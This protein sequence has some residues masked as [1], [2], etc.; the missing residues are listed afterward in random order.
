M[1]RELF[2]L[3]LI[4]ILLFFV[5]RAGLY[6]LYADRMADMAFAES[7]LSFLYGLRLDTMAASIILVVPALVMAFAPARFAPAAGKFLHVYTL[8]FL[9]IALF[10]ENATFPFVAQYDVRPNYLFV[11]YLE[12][13][14]EV[15]SMIVK[16]YPFELVVA[17]LMLALAVWFYRRFRFFHFEQGMQSVWWKRAILFPLVGA[18]LFLGIRSSLG[19]RP[20]NISD[21]LYSTNRMANEIAKNSLYSI[22]YAYKS[23][24]SE[25]SI[26][27]RYGRI[28][29]D[30]A[31][32][33]VSERLD[34]PLGKGFPFSRTVQSRFPADKPKNLVIFIQ[35]SMGAQ[36]VGFSGGDAEITPNMDKLSR[37]AL[38]FT[39]L[40]SNGTR[41]I[42]G[43][44]AMTSGWLPLAGEEVVKRNKSQSGFFTVASL[45]KP[46][47]Y[48]SSFIYGG[49]GRFDNMRSW[50]MGN[51]FDEVIEQKDFDSPSFVSSWGVCDEDLVVR[52]N[53]KFREHTRKGEKFVSVMFSQSNHSPF[54]LPDGKIEFIPGQPRQSA[55]NAIKYADFAI[56]R[57]FE[58]AK[59]EAYYKDT[60]FVV[61]ADHNVR[62]Y[63]DDTVP[64]NMFHIP[65][66]IVSEGVEPQK[67]DRIATQPDVLATA[68]DL[69]GV[70]L[71]Y[72]ILGH[73][74]FDESNPEVAFMMFNDAFAL[75][76]RDRVAILEPDK[77][78]QT[79][80]YDNKRLNPVPHDQKLERDALAL[81]T[82]LDDLYAKKL[83]RP[84]I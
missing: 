46:L 15:S 12:Y 28:D 21:A 37:D 70:D 9:L 23:Y 77:A 34:L 7:L 16:E 10:V 69:V 39:N 67:F 49:E 64:V 51:G 52:A 27:K 3:Y 24:R 20:A 81:I 72:P 63:G 22:G 38:V 47:G 53:E 56:G 14:Q 71:T 68:L 76:D 59:K 73:S 11:E 44:A 35:E 42:R 30:E 26:L 83:Y 31:Y 78:P 40:Y 36:F 74:M 5:G 50:Y 66:L 13:P 2:K 57:F 32:A 54:E 58:M 29:R 33:R 19:H 62:V 55:E 79:F 82:V 60:V 6:F 80:R 8:L 75:R 18:V 43:L 25:E 45:L 65:A 84:H 4:F 1:I 48:K 61:V 17:G 41:S